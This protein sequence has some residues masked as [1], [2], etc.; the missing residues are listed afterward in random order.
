QHDLGTGDPEA[1]VLRGF[2]PSLGSWQKWDQPLLER[3]VGALGEYLE[4]LGYSADPQSD[5]A[6]ISST[7]TEQA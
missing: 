5:P 2:R 7:L 3:A 1:Q 4:T 6:A